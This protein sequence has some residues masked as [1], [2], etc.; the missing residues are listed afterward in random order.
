MSFA[1][2]VGFN[3]PL[4]PGANAG[5]PADVTPFN[6]E[7]NAGIQVLNTSNFADLGSLFSVK[8]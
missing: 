6:C 7:H 4:I 1:A 5:C 2:V 8:P 3:V